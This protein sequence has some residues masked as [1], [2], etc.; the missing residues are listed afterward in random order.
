MTI[1]TIHCK[2]IF[3]LNVQN[4]ETKSVTPMSGIFLILKLIIRHMNLNT[5]NI[6]NVKF[7]Y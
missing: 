5:I 4:C 3:N 6:I 1:G 2:N 7:Y